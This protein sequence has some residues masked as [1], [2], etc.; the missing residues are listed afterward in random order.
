MDCAIVRMLAVAMAFI[1]APTFARA[2]P[3]TC[4]QLNERWEKYH[5]DLGIYSW[6]ADEFECPSEKAKIAAWMFF[7]EEQ[8]KK[9]GMFDYYTWLTEGVVETGRSRSV[10][11]SGQPGGLL[12][13]GKNFLLAEGSNFHVEAAQML[14]HERRHM[15]EAAPTH[16]FCDGRTGSQLVTSEDDRAQCDEWLVLAPVD[17]DPQGRAGA[18]SASVMFALDL[19][20]H[21]SL[22]DDERSYA[23]GQLERIVR[24]NF[25]KAGVRPEDLQTISAA[26]G[27][28]IILD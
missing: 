28:P 26:A 25:I 19:L 1:A 17:A 9:P 2:E 22:S 8:S 4:T 3:G 7:I 5:S 20:D 16:I 23:S 11:S 15:D 12:L 6:D 21:G 27:R 13:I 24:G 18:F 14:V 10:A